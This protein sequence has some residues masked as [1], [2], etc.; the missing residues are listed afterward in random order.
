M[1][2]YVINL[3][4]KDHSLKAG[5]S[6]TKIYIQITLHSV[7]ERHRKVQLSNKPLFIK[8]PS[9]FEKYSGQ[10]DNVQ[11]HNF[12]NTIVGMYSV[13]YCILF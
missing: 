8:K 10:L 11:I 13:L 3:L 2:Q 4:P 12:T 7:T 9:I 1:V 5:F 6:H